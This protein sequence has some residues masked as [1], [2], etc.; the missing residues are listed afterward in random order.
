MKQQWGIMKNRVLANSPPLVEALKWVID[1][2]KVPLHTKGLILKIRAVWIASQTTQSSIATS[3]V[4][5]V[6]SILLRYIQSGILSLHTG[7]QFAG[8]I[9]VKTSRWR[10]VEPIKH[11]S[12]RY[13]L[14]LEIHRTYKQVLKLHENSNLP[15]SYFCWF[16]YTS[17]L[18]KYCIYFI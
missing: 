9:K 2:V 4:W 3:K 11:K 10:V 17:K 16:N 13:I 6:S 12:L 1:N 18:I 5:D 8:A 7:L 15:Y 14:D